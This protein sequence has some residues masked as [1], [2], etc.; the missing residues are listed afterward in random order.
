MVA[1]NTRQ[2]DGIQKIV[3][4]IVQA[5]LPA[6]SH[7]KLFNHDPISSADRSKYTLSFDEQYA[8]AV[9]QAAIIINSCFNDRESNFGRYSARYDQNSNTLTIDASCACNTTIDV[10]QLAGYLNSKYSYSISPILSEIAASA[11]HQVNA[12]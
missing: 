11:Q 7:D 1:I 8:K 9:Q 10:E 3:L 5:I 4:D 6:T 2:S 12:L